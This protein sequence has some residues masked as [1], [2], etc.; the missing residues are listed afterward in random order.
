MDDYQK[1]INYLTERDTSPP[2]LQNI[3]DYFT[4]NHFNPTPELV[5]TVIKHFDSSPNFYKVISEY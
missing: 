3:I 1:I 4:H 2:T 5:K